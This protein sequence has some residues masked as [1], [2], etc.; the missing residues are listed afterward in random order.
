MQNKKQFVNLLK[1]LIRES[2]GSQSPLLES[3]VPSEAEI[4]VESKANKILKSQKK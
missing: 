4:L 3:P 2:L 1:Q